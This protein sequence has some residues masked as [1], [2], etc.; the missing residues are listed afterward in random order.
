MEI[1]DIVDAINALSIVVAGNKSDGG[2]DVLLYPFLTAIAGAASAFLFSTLQDRALDK[3]EK[4]RNFAKA[5][6]ELISDF[7][8]VAVGYW[9]DSYCASRDAEI[10]RS[11]LEIKTK[12]KVINGLVKEFSPF[13]SSQ[14]MIQELKTFSAEIY[15]L[16]TGGHFESVERERSSNIAGNIVAKCASIRI[17]NLKNSYI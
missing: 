16:S 5:I 13:I 8:N 6:N 14:T 15:G 11:E 9:L 17:K 2:L 10:K 12:L 4:K 7:E 1:S 3:R